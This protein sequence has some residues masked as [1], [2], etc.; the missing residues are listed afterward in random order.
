[1][2]RVA[3]LIMVV[4]VLWLPCSMMLSKTISKEKSFSDVPSYVYYRYCSLKSWLDEMINKISIESFRNMSFNGHHILASENI[5]PIVPDDIK[6]LFVDILAELGVDTISMNI[7][8]NVYDNIVSSYDQVVSRIR[9]HS[10]KL[11]IVYMVGENTF[12]HIPT[13]EEYLS[14]EINYTRKLVSKYKPE[15]Y[16]IL[17][18]IT[19][20]Q[21]RIGCTFTTDQWVKLITQ[22]HEVVKETCNTTKTFV[23]LLVEE[24]DRFLN[25]ILET[26]IDIIAFNVYGSRAAENVGKYITYAKEKSCKEVW[27]WENWWGSQWDPLTREP[28]IWFRDCYWQ[29]IN[30]KWIKLIAYIAQTHGAKMMSPFFTEQFV[31]CNH[32]YGKPLEKQFTEILEAVKNGNRTLTFQEYKQLIEEIKHQQAYYYLGQQEK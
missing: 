18:E 3:I 31:Y 26:E 15:F 21:K 14:L 1:M 22:V 16:G 20:M 32:E 7:Y 13:F 11:V 4:L 9:E 29:E 24:A 23:S 5:A 6:I 8:P 27:I 10:R 12:D 25:P 2:K 28:L 19:T 17:V 30:A